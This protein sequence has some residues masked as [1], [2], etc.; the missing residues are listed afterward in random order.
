MS[1]VEPGGSVTIHRLRPSRIG[2]TGTAAV[3]AL[4]A[5]L[6]ADVLTTWHGLSVGLVE[7]N[8][9]AVVAL[10]AG[11]VL[12]FVVMSALVLAITVGGAW[13]LDRGWG[14]E[15][16]QAWVYPVVGVAVVNWLAA[17]HNLLLILGY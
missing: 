6:C 7:T 1:N 3:V 9:A 15:H 13:I 4:L 12:G 11:G 14:D 10:E 2:W 5:G 17:V 16:P 8:P